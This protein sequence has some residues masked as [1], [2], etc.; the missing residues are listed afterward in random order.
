MVRA[1]ICRWLGS[2]VGKNE[3]SKK[4]NILIKERTILTSEGVCIFIC[5]LN[6]LFCQ[7][8]AGLT[9]WITRKLNIKFV[10]KMHGVADFHVIGFF[11]MT[12]L[13]PKSSDWE[14]AQSHC[15]QFHRQR[16]DV[17]MSAV[18]DHGRLRG[19]DV[20]EVWCFPLLWSPCSFKLWLRGSC[21]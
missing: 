6:P 7:T 20:A 9:W 8:L 4:I 17:R 14:I 18:G 5:G 12:F 11:I 13:F 16:N 1:Q 15:S 3:W 19:A 2:C 10:R 21:V